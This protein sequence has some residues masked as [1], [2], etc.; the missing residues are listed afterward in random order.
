MVLH[1]S[2]SKLPA[3]KKT[4]VGGTRKR[5][6]YPSQE[7]LASP[8]KAEGTQSRLSRKGSSKSESDTGSTK[9]TPHSTSDKVINVTSSGPLPKIRH[10]H[11]KKD[12]CPCNKSILSS[13]KLDC[14]NCKQY[15]H[16]D[17]VGLN[18]LSENSINKLH[19]WTCPFCWVSP[20]STVQ[21]EVDVCHIC[22][23]TLSLQQ[24]NLD[25]EAAL[26]HQKIKNVS[27]CCNLLR[28]SNFKELSERM[29]TLSEFDRHLQHLLLSEN[30]LK[31]LDCEI[32][33]LTDLIASSKSASES[34]NNSTLESINLNITE[35][36]RDVD[37]LAREP[38]AAPSI[39]EPTYKLLN[40][41]N[42][43]L[44]QLHTNE[45]RVSADIAQLKVSLQSVQSDHTNA[46]SAMPSTLPPQQSIES[47]VAHCPPQPDHASTE[48][49]QVPYSHHSEDFICPEEAQNLTNFLNSQ[50]FKHENGHSVISFGEPYTYTG[51][52]SSTNVP[53]IPTELKSLFDRINAL[54][55]EIFS[56][57]YQNSDQTAPLINSCLVN[58]YEGAESYLPKH[59]D[60]EVTIQPESSIFTVSLGP[61]CDIQFVDR[62]SGTRS[63]LTCQDR[64]LYHMTRRSQE[65]FE[66]LIEEGSI[67]SGTRYSLTFR[68]I[69]WTNKN[70]TCLMGDS[71]TGLLRFGNDKRGTFGKLMPGQ[72]F[73]SPRIEDLDP[74]S[75]MGYAN[76]VLLC[77]IND[78]R[79]PEVGSDNDVAG[80][81]NKL[82]LKINQ[83]KHLSPQTAVFVCRL[84]PTKDPQLNLKV[85]IFNRLIFFDLIPTCKGVVE[86]EGF[87]RFACNHVLADDLSKQ[88]DRNGR[89]DMLHLN[90]S[91]ARV[92]AGLIKYSVFFRL[93][94][95]V[96]KRRR[97][98][99]VDGRLYSNVASNPPALRRR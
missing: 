55:T 13:W 6:S 61:S 22:R 78:I 63:L 45:S 81:Y 11:R 7:D 28:H 52:K 42:L 39:S 32:R 23:N 46:S 99:R 69:S 35:L 68:C 79:Q 44:E 77:G 84:L 36:Q 17:C 33:K 75:C 86:V 62:F 76:V 50:T 90:R 29:S 40:E 24:T 16:A 94:G 49:H 64:S 98:N 21:T 47:L 37:S 59:S 71:N 30:S 53:P 12:S 85:D 1:P 58:K 15:W 31:G 70:S 80:C 10:E 8:W 97:T 3:V 82:K 4:P 9:S 72:K 95:G 19:E 38:R 20:I 93:N 27:E 41:I 18:G 67:E 54:Q 25:Y 83:I 2:G 92:L 43:K 74:V 48:H 65:V 5:D 51:S 73:W 91:G 87:L 56:N 96:D 14:R 26:V 57:K 34:F 89:P 66:H 60:R 88:Y